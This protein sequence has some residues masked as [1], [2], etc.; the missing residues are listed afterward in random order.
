MLYA[1]TSRYFQRPFMKRATLAAKAAR[2]AFK[3]QAYSELDKLMMLIGALTRRAVLVS[4]V[5]IMDFNGDG[6][7]AVAYSEVEAEPL[8]LEGRLN[9]K[10]PWRAKDIEHCEESSIE[11]QSIAVWWSGVAIATPDRQ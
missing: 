6:T 8:T 3:G 5:E 2:G 1:L 9:G 10:N 7:D 11:V 4:N